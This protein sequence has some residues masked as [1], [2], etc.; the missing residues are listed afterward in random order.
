MISIKNL[1]FNYPKQNNLFNDL[2]LD[3][4]PGLVY[5]LL[6]KNGA[7]K[8]T[9]LK[10]ISGLLFHTQGV[11][12]VA[13][14][15]PRRRAVPFLQ[16]IFFIPEE[17][18]TPAVSI[19]NYASLYGPFYPRFDGKY[20]TKQIEESGLKNSDKLYALSFGQRK[21]VVI[22]FGLATNCKVLILDEPTNGL[23][24]PTKSQFRTL[25]ASAV[26]PDRFFIISTHQVRD[27][28]DLLSSIIILDNGA[29][30]LNRSSPEIQEKFLFKNE[31]DEKARAMAIYSEKAPGGY[32]VMTENTTGKQSNIDLE[33]LF[34]AVIANSNT[35]NNYF[36]TGL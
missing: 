25:L 17:L 2:S 16:E 5:G 15:Q 33:I 13:G 26:C 8:T 6:G 11:C 7:G 1:T 18:Y 9:L 21:K 36:D 14:H 4:A 29:I 23:D 35:V 20:F 19:Q 3:I 31:P 32:A 30:M 28:E 10:I 22:A 34:N 12:T 24:I 27:V